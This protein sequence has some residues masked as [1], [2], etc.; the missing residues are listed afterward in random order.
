M[1]AERGTLAIDGVEGVP[2]LEAGRRLTVL[3]EGPSAIDA[4]T[5]ELLL[6]VDWPNEKVRNPDAPLAGRTAPFAQVAIEAPGQDIRSVRADADGVFSIELP[7]EE[8][9][10]ALSV[11]TTV[12]TGETRRSEATV[13]LDSKPPTATSVEIGWGP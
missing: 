13:E 2:A 6:Q 4:A 1:T 10:N 5:L 3:A 11:T 7:L 8:G 9:A 12:P